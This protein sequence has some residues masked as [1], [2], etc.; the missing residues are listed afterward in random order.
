MDDQ[1]NLS[2]NETFILVLSRCRAAILPCNSQ[3]GIGLTGSNIQL[4]NVESSRSFH[5]H[6]RR[7]GGDAHGVSS[8][9]SSYVRIAIREEF[10]MPKPLE[11]IVVLEAP[12]SSVVLMLDVLSDLGA[13][14]IK[15]E[16]PKGGDPFRGQREFQAY[17]PNKRTSRSILERQMVRMFCVTSSER[18]T[19]SLGFSRCDGATWLRLE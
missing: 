16:N 19:C 12:T 13:D 8:R 6:R 15:I 1:G 10:Q 2:R 4:Q 17:N 14:V 5:H 3:C 11:G 18:P 9:S 7:G